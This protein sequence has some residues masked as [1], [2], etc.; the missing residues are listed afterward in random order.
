MVAAA[1]AR[2]D[3]AVA[4]GRL[5]AEAAAERLTQVT[6]RITTFVE[7]GFPAGQDRP[8][9]PPAGPEPDTTDDRP[10]PRP[11]PPLPRP[12]PTDVRQ[13]PRQL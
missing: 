11:R 9:R 5:D 8:D 10:A 7:E 3:E 1:E 6:E 2:I 13:G 12:P 4:D